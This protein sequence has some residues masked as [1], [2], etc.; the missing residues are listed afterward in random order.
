LGDSCVLLDAFR[1][2]Q[3][4]AVPAFAIADFDALGN[5][6][7]LVKIGTPSCATFTILAAK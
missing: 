5:A 7:T 1:G 3:P 2:G 6:M 4:F